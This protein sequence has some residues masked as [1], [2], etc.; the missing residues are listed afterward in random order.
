[1]KTLILPIL[2]AGPVLF[3]ET[4]TFDI[5][6]MTCGGCVAN[7]QKSVCDGLHFSKENCKVEIGK[8][9][10]TSEKIDSNLISSA[11]SKAGYEVQNPGPDS[12]SSPAVDL[13]PS[14]TPD[15]SSS[16]KTPT[17]AFPAKKKKT[18]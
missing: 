15:E 10:I 16:A 11:V 18:K 3:G 7:I 14:S 13:S 8:L 2:L 6:G 12:P 1:M 17:A 4:K 5:K 9:T